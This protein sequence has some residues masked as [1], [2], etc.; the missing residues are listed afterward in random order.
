MEFAPKGRSEGPKREFLEW[1]VGFTDGEGNFNIKLTDFN[2]NNFKYVQFTFQIGLHKD[3]ITVLEYIMNNLKCGHISKSDN[4][5][6]Y[7]VNDINS[8]KN[9]ILPIFDSVHL[10]SSKYYH[11]LL[12]KKAVMLTENKQHLKNEG[13]L[14]IIKLKKTMQSM[15]GKWIPESNKNMNITKYW[16][17]GFIDAEG[18]F[19][20]NK[21]V[22]RFKLE[23][24]VKELE[25]YNKIREF[26]GVG[27]VLLT[28]P[29][30]Y[31][32]DSHPTI[33]FEINKIKLLINILI[34]LMYEDNNLLLK[35]LK[36]QDFLL[37]LKLVD[38]YYNGYHTIEQGKK[39]FD[40]I[41]IHMNKYRLTTNAHLREDSLD[42]ITISD[43]ETSLS[44]LRQVESPYEIKEGIR[45]YRNT[46]KLVSESIEIIVISNG[47]LRWSPEGGYRNTYKSMSECAQD[48]GVSRKIIKKCLS[49]GLSYKGL[50]FVLN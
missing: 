39:V 34:P 6:N 7:F 50:T 9:I 8:L 12:F 2:N 41:K 48:I 19:S 33:V 13:K 38:I 14:E 35:T 11:F 30:V 32:E 16:L 20:T 49:T 27:N 3:D 42:F 47:A 46:N 44:R 23:N 24:H 28:T 31:R 37:W 10:N 17:A 5:I 22:P 4:R 18:T 1:F 26:I 21:Y 36:S 15:S 45:Y 43:I 25:L 29:R 40:S